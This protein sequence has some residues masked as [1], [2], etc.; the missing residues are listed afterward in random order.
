MC[1]IFEDLY[2][3]ITKAG[4]CFEEELVFTKAKHF[5]ELF[6]SVGAKKREGYLPKN[7]TPY[8]H[9]LLYHVPMFVSRLGSLI[10]F[11]GQGV[12]KTNDILK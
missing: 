11:S 12:E 4:E 7:I 5:T 1:K 8:M 9:T 2:K 6:F 3:Y 10:Q